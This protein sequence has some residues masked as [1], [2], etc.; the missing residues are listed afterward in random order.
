MKMLFNWLKILLGFSQL[1]RQV[2]LLDNKIAKLQKSK[3]KSDDELERYFNNLDKIQENFTEEH[4]RASVAVKKA[5][6]DN[7]KLSA[8]LETVNEELNTANKILIPSLVAAN[9]V[10]L[11]RWESESAIHAMRAA[12]TSEPKGIE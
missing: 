2:S 3:L 4:K 8:A 6:L 1:S 10:L 5:L 11:R 12:A 7:E 9:D